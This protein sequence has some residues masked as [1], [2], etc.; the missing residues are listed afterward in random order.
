MLGEI[1]VDNVGGNQKG[2]RASLKMVISGGGETCPLD[3]IE[4]VITHRVGV[5][6]TGG[7]MCEHGGV[8]D[9]VAQLVH[10]AGQ[11]VQQL[12]ARGPVVGRK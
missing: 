8:D 6:E 1:S 9:L 12:H 5:T 2:G 10:V 4:V 11:V 7:H 3:R